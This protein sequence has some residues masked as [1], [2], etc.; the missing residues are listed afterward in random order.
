MKK[1]WT[2]TP[3]LIIQ[4]LNALARRNVPLTFCQHG[5]KATRVYIDRL[6]QTGNEHGVLL[7]K[8]DGLEI[9]DETAILFYHAPRQPLRGFQSVILRK[10]D[11]QILISLPSEI[12]HVERRRIK[13]VKTLGN[14]MVTFTLDG[15]HRLNTWRVKDISLEGAKIVGSM[16]YDMESVFAPLTFTLGMRYEDCERVVIVSRA[17]VV[18]LDECGDGLVEYG[19]HFNVGDADQ[20]TLDQY[21]MLRGEEDSDLE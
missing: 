14:S 3:S 11:P 13:R 21:I 1:R 5:G 18:R 10:K 4:E 15:A 12:F 9:L 7:K 20:A 19:V 6:L 8:A 2:N 16:K 17:T